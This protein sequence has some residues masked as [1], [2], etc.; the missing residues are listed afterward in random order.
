MVAHLPCLGDCL[1]H[2]AST[3]V[4]QVSSLASALAVLVTEEFHA[5]SL[6]SALPTLALCY[7]Y[8]VDILACLPN[9][10]D[11]N[12]SSKPFSGPLHL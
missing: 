6:D 8:N 5:P 4:T 9:I 2:I 11:G 3:E 1:P 12:L 7:P 10:L